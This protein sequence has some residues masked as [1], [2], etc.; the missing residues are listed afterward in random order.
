[1]A[2]APLTDLETVNFFNT[3]LSSAFD[4]SIPIVI[5]VPAVNEVSSDISV[6]PV[7]KSIFGSLPAS[8]S[9]A[10][11]KAMIESSMKMLN[12]FFIIILLNDDTLII[13]YPM[14]REE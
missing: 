10:V 4:A 3:S 6:R 5:E 2:A 14:R 9:H 12:I 1:V 13:S 7:L 11:I 8:F